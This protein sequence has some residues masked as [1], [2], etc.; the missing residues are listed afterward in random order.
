[1]FLKVFWLTLFPDRSPS[2][3]FPGLL[4]VFV[5][6]IPDKVILDHK[7]SYLVSYENFHF[8]WF[9]HFS[10]FFAKNWKKRKFLKLTKYDFLW[11]KITLSGIISTKTSKSPGKSSEVRTAFWRT[12]ILTQNFS[13]FP[14]VSHN[15]YLRYP[16]CCKE[17]VSSP[18]E[19]YRHYQTKFDFF[20]YTNKTT[21]KI[22]KSSVAD[23]FWNFYVIMGLFTV[24]FHI[25]CPKIWKM[26]GGYLQ[27]G[28]REFYS[29]PTPGFL[30]LIY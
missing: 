14:G 26:W 22:K 10:L 28:F 18:N 25:V 8:L 7:K 29:C 16:R 21:T 27:R 24:D 23:I 17:N 1:M 20:Y 11:S 30:Q 12:L 2:P 6:N 5:E 4:L 13:S 15:E 3:D 19:I 9:F